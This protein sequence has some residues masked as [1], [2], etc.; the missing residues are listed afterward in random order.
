M[1]PDDSASSIAVPD[2]MLAPDSYVTSPLVD[3]EMGGVA[4]NDAS[5]GLRVKTWQLYVAGNTVTVKPEGGNATA[6]F[7]RAGIS[8]LALA[9]D[10]N[11]RP[12]VAFLQSQR[13]YLYWFDSQS[14]G[15]VFTSFGAATSPRLA[16]DDKRPSQLGPRSDI[17]LA[18]IRD[19][20][21]WYRQQRDRFLI[22]RK[23][24]DN[25]VPGTRLRAMGMGKA[26]RMQFELIQP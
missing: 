13:L 1:L 12:A 25:L 26:L 24:R 6:L 10:Q 22:E 3:Y 9:F 20:A 14:G 4:L 2:L 21:L 8:E 7:S 15:F 5:Q 11:M 19:D 18:Y 23:L 16:L 17:I